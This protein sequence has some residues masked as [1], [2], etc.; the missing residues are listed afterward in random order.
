MDPSLPLVWEEERR[1]F[2]RRKVGTD[3]TA[4][5]CTFYSNLLYKEI[6]AYLTFLD[7]WID[8]EIN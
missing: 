2:Q 3:R 6:F 1:G 7:C 5:G 4:G 8:L